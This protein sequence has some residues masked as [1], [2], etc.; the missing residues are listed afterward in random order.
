MR[1]EKICA[2]NL[3]LVIFM[4][5]NPYVRWII[6]AGIENIILFAT[7]TFC[8]FMLS[9]HVKIVPFREKNKVFIAI[10][11]L[12][13]I[14][15]FILSPIHGIRIGPL[16]W[17]LCFLII[18]SYKDFIVFK[19]YLYLKKLFVWISIFALIF[20]VLN[21][22]KFPLPYY[23]Y[24]PDFRYSSL[25][26]YHIYG[27]AISLYRGSSTVGA[28]G[29][30]R[31]VGVFA[32]PGHFG[33]Y[34]G[35]ILAIERFNLS[36]KDNLLLLITGVLTFSTAFYGI[37]GLGF[38]YNFLSDKFFLKK[39]RKPFI[40]I[41]LLLGLVFLFKGNALREVTYGR[42]IKNNSGN[43]TGIIELVEQRSNESNKELFS[44]FV[45]SPNVLFGMGYFID[46][47]KFQTTNW[48]G[49]FFRFGILGFTI[50]ILVIISIVKEAHK[51]KY[52][53]L[54]LSIAILI[55]SH[56][57]YLYYN[58]G[59]FMLLYMATV[60]NR[61][62]IKFMK[63]RME[64]YQILRRGNYITNPRKTL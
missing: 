18:L 46:H 43:K 63:N 24:T 15:Y 64:Q 10:A 62:R 33:I 21:A 5:M 22:I 31:I 28:L 6:P 42:V 37:L 16:I 26:N 45:K 58:P 17:V 12:I 59:I 20:W 38:L 7:T 40:A 23:T 60:A 50:I 9:N 54:L 36:K 30:E 11:L 1:I 32:E 2:L 53:L 34:I 48:R 4:L 49:I 41:L 13:Y 3:T 51:F 55:L 52:G 27:L 56:R 61:I 44:S 35:L 47:T 57:S 8:T 19:S 39:M 29:L 14:I 25:D